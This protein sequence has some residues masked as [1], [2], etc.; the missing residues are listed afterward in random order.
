MEM[1]LP[2]CLL[3]GQWD[4]A[5]EIAQKQEEKASAG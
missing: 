3:Y 4:K 1:A 2:Y 5:A